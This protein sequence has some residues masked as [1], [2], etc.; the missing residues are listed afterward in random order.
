MKFQF[1]KDKKWF[2]STLNDRNEIIILNSGY[3][4]KSRQIIEE[5][6]RIKKL[7]RNREMDAE[8]LEYLKELE[9]LKA[10][11]TLKR[12]IKY[13]QRFKNGN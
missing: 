10:E 4:S 12:K 9:A 5:I 11:E 7:F 3:V 6:I 2:T 13:K 1:Q 8:T